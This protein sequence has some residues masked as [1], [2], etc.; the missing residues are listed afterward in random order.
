[1][2]WPY[3]LGLFTEATFTYILLDNL[4]LKWH[5]YSKIITNYP[6]CLLKWTGKNSSVI[7]NIMSGY[8]KVFNLLLQIS[9]KNIMHIQNQSKNIERFEIN[10]LL[11]RWFRK[12]CFTIAELSIC[13]CLSLLFRYFVI[14]LYILI[15]KQNSVLRW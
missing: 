10:D 4:L 7:I 12:Y 6:K 15:P 5:I 2:Q 8:L 1:M 14:F 13:Y 11:M 9:L 3:C